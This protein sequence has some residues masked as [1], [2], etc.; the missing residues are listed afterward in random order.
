MK[1]LIRKVLIESISERKK[2]SLF[3]LWDR[4]KSMGKNP[5]CDR[6]LASAIGITYYQIRSYLLEWYG[7]IEKVFNI[8]KSKLWN[9]VISTEIF[10]DYG[11]DVGGYDFTFKLTKFEKKNTKSGGFDLYIDCKIIEGGVELI[12]TTNEYIDLTKTIEDD[13]LSWEIYNEVRELVLD[14]VYKFI[15]QYGLDVDLEDINFSRV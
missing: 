12:M 11:I 6:N 13:N 2:L 10:R 4:E 14:L 7:G 1:K 8:V 5:T 3:K 15:N 9:K